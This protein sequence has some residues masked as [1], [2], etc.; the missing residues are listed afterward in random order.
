MFLSF[1]SA[2]PYDLQTVAK[3][4]TTGFSFGTSGVTWLISDRVWDGLPDT[5]RKVM[6]E[7]GAAAEQNFCTYADSHEDA[8]QSAMVKTVTMIPLDKTQQDALQARLAPLVEDWA[9]GLEKRGLP[10]HRVA[11]EFRHA[12]ASE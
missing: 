7:A 2:K 1:L 10:A 8:E 4:A 3:Y 5:V 9:K 11:A 6:M 12:L